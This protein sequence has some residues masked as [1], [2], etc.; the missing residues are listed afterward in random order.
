M[1]VTFPTNGNKDKNVRVMPDYQRA[2]VEKYWND[3]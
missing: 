2:R 1:I 3:Y